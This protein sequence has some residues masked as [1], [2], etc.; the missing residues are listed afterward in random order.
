MEYSFNPQPVVLQSK[1]VRLEPLSLKHANDLHE[2][3]QEEIIW[4]YLPLEVQKI[5]RIPGNGSAQR[6]KGQKGDKRWH[7]QLSIA[8]VKKPSAQQDI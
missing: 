1:I 7:L 4:Q 8:P 2:I 6:V 3:G 5:L